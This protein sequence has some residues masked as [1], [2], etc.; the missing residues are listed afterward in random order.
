MCKALAKE[1]T[2]DAEVTQKKYEGLPNSLIGFVQ[3]SVALITTE[4][5]APSKL[6]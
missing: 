3:R 5:F 2:Y 4:L 1:Q 6:K